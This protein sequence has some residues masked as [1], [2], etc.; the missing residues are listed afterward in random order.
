VGLIEAGDRQV[1]TYSGGMKRRLDLA[2]AL[3]HGPRL[4][5]LDEPTE[6][7]DPA[8]RAS[9]WQEV[10]RLNREEGMTVFLTTHYLE[11]ADRLADRLAIIDHGSIVAEGTPEDLKA[12]IGTDIVHVSVSVDQLDRA[13]DVL[14]PLEG[15]TEVQV[16][17]DGLTLFVQDGSAAI[18]QIIRMLDSAGVRVG[19][20][21]VSPASL[22]EVFLRATGSRLEGARGD[23]TT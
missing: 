16:D 8:S 9:V 18:P 12:S 20:V 21:A 14:H 7:L 22:D 11:E 17:E 13:K 19:P 23:P 3:V 4:L 2:S 5:F 1:K 15:L 10:Q 6:G